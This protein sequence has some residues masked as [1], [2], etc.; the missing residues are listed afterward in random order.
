MIRRLAI[1]LVAVAALTGCDRPAATSTSP[2]AADRRVVVYASLDRQYSEPIL[3]E[4]TKRTGI[5]V[6]AV[7]DTES[8]KTVGLYNRIVA[9]A[10]RPR[11]DVF[12]NN[13]ILNTLRLKEAGLLAPS[14]PPS[15]ADYA[16]AMRDDDGQ[17]FGFAAR[18][19]VLIVNTNLVPEQRRPRSIDALTDPAWRGKTGIAKPLFGTTATHVAVL[20]SE[21]GRERLA[22]LFAAWRANDVQ[23]LGGNRDCARLVA[24]GQLA[25]ALTDTDDAIEERDAGKPVEI[26]FPDGRDGERGTL[27][28]PNT[29][30][31]IRSGPHPAAADRLIDYLLSPEVEERLVHGASAQIP[32]N[33]KVKATSRAVPRGGFRASAV[34]FEQAAAEFSA[35]A[36]IVEA[37]LLKPD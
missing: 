19:R 17:W 8:T 15:A 30:A 29:L 9:E 6:D 11:C 26:V 23:I 5:A 37:E 22:S 4:F 27:L 1:I 21:L 20:S 28:I 10:G 33:A 2:A 14:D 7:Y 36:Q 12:W 18:A 24:D 3:A 35:V 25:F 34:R 32:L 31:K 16:P 13:E